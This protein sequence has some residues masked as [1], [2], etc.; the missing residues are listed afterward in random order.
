MSA[1]GQKQTLRAAER[2]PSFYH[3]VGGGEQRLRDGQAE[4]FR[5]FEVDHQLKLGRRLNG[6][7]G[8]LGSLED[9]IDLRSRTPEILEGIRSIRHQ[10]TLRDAYPVGVDGRHLVLLCQPH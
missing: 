10:A 5:G 9:A 4:P 8:R 7:I 2:A 6:K 3:L 1:L